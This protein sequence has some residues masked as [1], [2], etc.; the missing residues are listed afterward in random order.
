MEAVPTTLA[1]P[2]VRRGRRVQLGRAVFALTSTAFLVAAA[3]DIDA[4]TY[5]T[6]PYL[7]LNLAIA[8]IAL[9]LTTRRPRASGLLGAGGH[10]AV[11]DGRASSTDMPS[12]RS[13]PT[14]APG[15]VGSRRPG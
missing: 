2:D 1:V 14:Q 4:R 6:M 9:L 7:G 12:G 13:W 10:G 15:P 8:L 11:G 5:Q 3:L